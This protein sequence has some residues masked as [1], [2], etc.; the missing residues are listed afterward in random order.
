MRAAER[1]GR[2]LPAVERLRRLLPALWA[3]VLLCIALVATPAPFALLE[4]ADAGRVV[5]RV[6]LQEA[7]FSLLLAT[8]LLLLERRIARRRSEAGA[9]SVLGTDTLLLLSTLF[10]TVAGYFGVQPLLADARAGQGSFGFGTLHAVSMLLFGL[11]CALVLWLAWRA[12]AQPLA[13]EISP[14]PFS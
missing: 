6:L 11:K 9:G 2:P 13:A 1:P 8:L 7:W 3:G 14:R 5:A 12:A 4:R 10:F